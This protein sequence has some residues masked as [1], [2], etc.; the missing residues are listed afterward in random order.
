MK[1]TKHQVS[2]LAIRGVGLTAYPAEVV[3][4]AK[5]MA[6]THCKKQ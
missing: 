3:Q 4:G 2:L 1:N 5:M 6:A